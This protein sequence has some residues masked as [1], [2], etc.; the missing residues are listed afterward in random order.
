MAAVEACS[1]PAHEC[2]YENVQSDNW[3]QITILPPANVQCRVIRSALIMGYSCCTPVVLLS[4]NEPFTAVQYGVAAQKQTCCRSSIVRHIRMHALMHLLIFL[5]FNFLACRLS[6]AISF[7]VFAST[8]IV[9]KSQR[10]W[11]L[12]SSW[13]FSLRLRFCTFFQFDILTTSTQWGKVDSRQNN[14]EMMIASLK[15]ESRCN[16]RALEHAD[17]GACT[18]SYLSKSLTPLILSMKIS[19][20]YFKRLQNIIIESKTRQ[21]SIATEF[22]LR[23]EDSK[24]KKRYDW[25]Q[26]YSACTA[27]IQ[28]GNALRF[29]TVF[30]TGDR[31]E[32]RLI[33]K[34]A[35]T[36]VYA[37]C[38][39]LHITCYATSRVGKLDEIMRKIRLTPQDEMKNK[40]RTNF[41]VAICWISISTMLLV[42]AFAFF[43]K[44]P[45]LSA[46]DSFNWYLAPFYSYIFL[47]ENWGILAKI[48]FFPVHFLA[49]TASHFPLVLTQRLSAVLSGHY[50]QLNMRFRR[51]VDKKG[52]FR[53]DIK[54]VARRHFELTDVVKSIDSF[55]MFS[56]AACCCCCLPIIMIIFHTYVTTGYCDSLSAAA[57]VLLF[58]GNILG[59]SVSLVSA[60]AVNVEVRYC[61]MVLDFI[62]LLI[63]CWHE[64]WQQP[65][66]ENTVCHRRQALRG[67]CHI[68]LH[69]Q[70]AKN[71]KFFK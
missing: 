17:N 35:T 43:V 26:I 47:N 29:T 44:I 15:I 32:S 65:R 2:R 21:Q 13:E 38:A 40:R 20:L 12:L 41:L 27:I 53:D 45:Y 19:G 34:M 71:F 46:G 36:S 30:K 52:C 24:R 66:S 16:I 56:N 9:Q 58:I 10:R 25:W 64:N 42:V 69:I 54:T 70:V 37:L 50:R 5:W 22:R 39:I 61:F 55:M 57:S 4:E 11:N 28:C 49:L 51:A 3:M 1:T 67:G 23:V 62:D 7:V 14:R 60:I 33:A 68:H 31:F 59:L 18:C 63:L 6:D 48:C 8:D